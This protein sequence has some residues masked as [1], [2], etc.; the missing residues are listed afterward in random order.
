MEPSSLTT[1]QMGGGTFP[2]APTIAVTSISILIASS[3]SSA[4]IMVAAGFACPKNSRRR[5]QM[6]GKSVR[7]GRM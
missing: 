7:S 6:A 2:P 1:Y 4:C 5:G 3:I